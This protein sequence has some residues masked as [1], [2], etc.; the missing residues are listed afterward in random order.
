MAATLVEKMG[1][2]SLDSARE[3]VPARGGSELVAV[4]FKVAG[5]EAFEVE[6]EP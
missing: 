3:E 6:I 2:L 5:M 4:T 1:A